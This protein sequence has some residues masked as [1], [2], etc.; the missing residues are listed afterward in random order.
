MH[1]CAAHG[2]EVTQTRR[3]IQERR[4]TDHFEDEILHSKHPDDLVLNLAQLRSASVI[5]YFR[6][7]RRFT[8]LSPDEVI[9]Y[10]IKNREALDQEAKQAKESQDSRGKGKRKAKDKGSKPG[11]AKRPRATTAIA[12]VTAGPSNLADSEGGSEPMRTPSHV[13]FVLHCNKS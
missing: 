9:E 6:S 12:E 3:V 4:I 11:P 7:D 13:P 2:C 1:N 5:Q 10:A 8:D